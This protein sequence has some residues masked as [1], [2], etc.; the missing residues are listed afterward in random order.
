MVDNLRTSEPK[1]VF[2]EALLLKPSQQSARVITI[3]GY[4][5]DRT[6]S[7]NNMHRVSIDNSLL[8]VD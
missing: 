6:L 7:G 4:S 8:V 5:D 1:H 2:F 3:Q